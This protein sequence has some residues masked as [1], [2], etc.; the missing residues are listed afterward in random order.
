MLRSTPGTTS[1]L[2]YANVTVSLYEVPVPAARQVP[3]I[4]AGLPAVMDS[5]AVKNS[6]KESPPEK[7]TA[8]FPVMAELAG[9]PVM[10]TAAG[11]EM[12]I[13]MTTAADP[14][15]DMARRQA[16]AMRNFTGSC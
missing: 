3:E 12:S 15:W 13:V 9:K 2:P 10:T 6:R 7:L 11:F 16:E 1:G 4:T 8:R 14:A 5:L